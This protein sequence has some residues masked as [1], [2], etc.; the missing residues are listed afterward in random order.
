M[1]FDCVS[2]NNLKTK[3][4]LLLRIS[5]K[6]SEYVLPLP[7][8]VRVQI[9]HPHSTLNVKKQR[10]P[11]VSINL[12]DTYP[13]TFPHETRYINIVSSSTLIY[14]DYISQ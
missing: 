14:F 12:P 10:F 5:L 2:L 9:K 8:V 13:T 4:K 6:Y 11:L 1:Y 7:R 3:Y